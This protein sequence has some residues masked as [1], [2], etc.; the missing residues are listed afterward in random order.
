VADWVPGS[1]PPSCF[2][3]EEEDDE[4]VSGLAQVGKTV[5]LRRLGCG[6]VSASSIF[7][8]SVSFL[9]FPIFCFAISNTGF[10]LFLQI[11]N[12]GVF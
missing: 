2:L 8:C 7:F 12:L 10:N 5:G 11:L 1:S 4:I 9:L 3:F 6:P